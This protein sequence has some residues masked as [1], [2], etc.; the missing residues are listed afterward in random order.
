VT[1]NN[2]SAFADAYSWNF[3]DANNSSSSEVSPSFTYTQLGAYTVTLTASNSQNCTHAKTALIDV[4]VPNV[5]AALG[6][7][8]LADD[9]STGSKRA[10]VTIKNNGNISFL[11]PVVSMNLGG[12]VSIKETVVG[13]ISVGGSLSKTLN[14]EI[15]PTQIS[16]VCAKVIVAADVFAD[17]DEQCVSLAQD[18]VVLSPYPNPA[19]SGFTIDWIT[20]SAQEVRVSVFKTNGQIAFD[21]TVSAPSGLTQYKIETSSWASGLYLVRVIGSNS[22][23]VFRVAV[24]N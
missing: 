20:T 11:N 17:N 1:F 2:N 9:P 4:V 13:M 19:S 21:Q 8:T 12:N 6:A 14:L 5:D 16:Y 22:E 3:G 23:K 24:A 18:E 10:I 7:F 15:V